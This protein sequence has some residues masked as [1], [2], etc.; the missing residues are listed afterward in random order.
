MAEVDTAEAVLRQQA[1]VEDF[2]AKCNAV[3]AAGI[4]AFGDKWAGA[5][6]DLALLDDHG[7]IPMD[8]LHVALETEDPA[9]VLFEL[10]RDLEKAGELID[11]P[12][13]K[14]AIAMDKLVATTAR[15]PSSS[16]WSR[17]RHGEARAQR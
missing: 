11:M 7:R 1:A 15:R 12:A 13:I 2:N 4:R 17:C 9:K 3:E 8:I 16:K 10:S 14:R 5:K 6:Q